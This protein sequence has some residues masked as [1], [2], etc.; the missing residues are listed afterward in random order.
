M[1]V[2]APD[3]FKALKVNR[4]LTGA[5]GTDAPR[6]EPVR[7]WSAVHDPLRI[8]LR[9]PRRLQLQ[10]RLP[11]AAGGAG[12]MNGGAAIVL[13]D[14]QMGTGPALMLDLDEELRASEAKRRVPHRAA[15]L[16]AQLPQAALE[17]EKHIH[18]H[19][20]ARRRPGQRQN[21]GR[22]YACTIETTRQFN[23]FLLERDAAAPDIGRLLPWPPPKIDFRGLQLSRSVNEIGKMREQNSQ[24]T[25]MKP[26]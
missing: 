12:V 15:F 21:R 9:E 6:L 22:R 2:R 19:L 24:S 5:A 1:T 10:Q 18:A 4:G 7:K 13:G 26:S 20:L 3:P 25:L 17:V 16:I 8:D 23:H 11:V 14:E